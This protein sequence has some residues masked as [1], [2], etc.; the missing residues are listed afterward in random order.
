MPGRKAFGISKKRLN[1]GSVSAKEARAMADKS[2]QS[3]K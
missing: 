1:G 2:K 3:K